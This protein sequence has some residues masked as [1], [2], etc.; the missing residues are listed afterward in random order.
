MDPNIINYLSALRLGE[1]QI[2]ENMAIVPLF[3][4]PNGGPDYGLL[5]E[6]MDQALISVTE[7]NRSG[8]VPELKVI[9]TSPRPILLLDGEELIGAKQNRV[10]NTSILLKGNSETFV[11]VSCTEQGRWHYTSTVFSNSGVIMSHRSR[12]SKTD[13]VTGSLR[14]KRGYSSDQIGIWSDIETLHREAGT[15]SQTR[16]M[17]DVYTAKT[18]DLGAYLGAFECVAHQQGSL[19]FINGEPVGLDVIPRQRAYQ[20]LHPKLIKSY[21]I[22]AL[23]QSQGGF[24]AP[25]LTKARA[26]LQEAQGCE[27]NIFTS[28]GL[29]YDYR[30]WGRQVVGSA[31]VFEG[32]IIHLALF[33]LDK[34]G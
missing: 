1:L 18:Q 20:A 21:A 11:P 3:T 12:A 26:F 27:D 31:L 17:R 9:T 2:F 24:D 30:F 34:R 15:T 23:L 25:S 32:Y 5:K 19:V 16:A 22:D 33:R 10:L 6:A 29:G 13:T 28:V 4:S 7:V 14:S 8:S